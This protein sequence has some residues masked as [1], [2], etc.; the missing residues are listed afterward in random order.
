MQTIKSESRGEVGAGQ[1]S[2]FKILYRYDPAQPGWKTLL[3]VNKRYCFGVSHWLYC[4]VLSKRQARNIGHCC[5]SIFN[6]A[7]FESSFFLPS[8]GWGPYL[9]LV[10]YK[11]TWIF[12]S[13]L[14]FSHDV[15]MNVYDNRFI[16][17]TIGQSHKWQNCSYTSACRVIKFRRLKIYYID[18][19]HTRFFLIKIGVLFLGREHSEALGT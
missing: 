5:W 13:R 12:G 18:M 15:L 2:V 4:C 17:L 3:R 6:L 1:V 10:S 19:V 8:L 14:G 7:K 9:I 16:K 11:P